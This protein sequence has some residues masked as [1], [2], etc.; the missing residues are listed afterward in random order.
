MCS[1]TVRMKISKL[2][3]ENTRFFDDVN[4]TPQETNIPGRRDLRISPCAKGARAI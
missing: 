3:L 2:R 1:D 4:V